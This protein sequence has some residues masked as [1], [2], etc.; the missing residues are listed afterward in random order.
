VRWEGRTVSM[1]AVDG[2]V[3]GSEILEQSVGA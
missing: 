3:R 1:F 2:D